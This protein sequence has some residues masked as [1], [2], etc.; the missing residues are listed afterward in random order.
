MV[1][2]INKK[3]LAKI[4]EDYKKIYLYGREEGKTLRDIISSPSTKFIKDML[5]AL[6]FEIEEHLYEFPGD[7]HLE[8]K[9]HEIEKASKGQVNKKKD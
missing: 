6:H 4:E 7:T 5:D 3:I 8:E 1:Y 2:D 9:F